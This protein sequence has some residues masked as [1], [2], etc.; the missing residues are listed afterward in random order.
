MEVHQKGA[1][2]A[3]STIQEAPGR[4]AEWIKNKWT[5]TKVFFSELWSNITNS[6]SRSLE[7]F[8]R[9]CFSSQRCCFRVLAINGTD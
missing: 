7:R 3:W 4:A 2:G 5:E 8:K 9:S 1:D 6:A